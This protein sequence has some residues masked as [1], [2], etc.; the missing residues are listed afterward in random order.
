[1]KESR[2]NFL[3]KAG[4]LAGAFSAINLFKEL[5]AADFENA[6]KTSGSA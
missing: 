1:M 5:H 3:Q 6:N 2:R 4:M